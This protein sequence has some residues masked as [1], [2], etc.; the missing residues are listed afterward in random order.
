MEEK[1]MNDMIKYMKMIKGLPKEQFIKS[2]NT[3]AEYRLPK[4]NDYSMARILSEC[5]RKS[6]ERIWKMNTEKEL[7][8]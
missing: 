3:Y 1:E 2:V 7:Q 4:M 5:L 8:K 6:E